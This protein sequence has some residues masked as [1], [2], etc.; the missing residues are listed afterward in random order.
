MTSLTKIFCFL[1]VE[2]INLFLVARGQKGII[3]DLARYKFAIVAKLPFTPIKLTVNV[4]IV[5]HD[6]VFV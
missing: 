3:P 6:N 5:H 1:I 4:F 2:P